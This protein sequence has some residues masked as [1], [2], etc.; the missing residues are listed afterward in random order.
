MT[1]MTNFGGGQTIVV[2]TRGF[3]SIILE[4]TVIEET[5]APGAWS[6]VPILHLYLRAQFWLPCIVNV[7][8]IVLSGDRYV[9]VI[10]LLTEIC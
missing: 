3:P 1:L 4:S 10:V 8:Q 2:V 7:L 5:L 6:E 9:F